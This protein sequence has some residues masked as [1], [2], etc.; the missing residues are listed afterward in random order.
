MSK[1]YARL[2]V[3]WFKHLFEFRRKVN[4]KQ[5]YCIDYRDL[6]KD[7]LATFEKLY[8]H[9]GWTM[10]QA[11]REKLVAAT[12]FRPATPLSEIIRLTAAA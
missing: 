12:G 8:A 9:F 10:S 1:A 7:P 3:Q 11:Y 5:Y 2:A 6:T 4:P